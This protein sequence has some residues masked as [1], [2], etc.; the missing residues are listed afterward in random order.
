MAVIEKK[1]N[2]KLVLE[3]DNGDLEKINSVMEKWNFVDI[4]SML[5]FMVSLLL[6]TERNVLYID[7]NK[8]PEGRIPAD[9]LIKQPEQK[10][11]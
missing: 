6:I 2:N 7:K 10:N 11:G 5:R 3:V 8:L 1:E 9:H 4:Q